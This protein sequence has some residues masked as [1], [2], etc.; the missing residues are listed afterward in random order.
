MDDNID[1]ATEPQLRDY[2]QAGVITGARI[3]RS[4]EGYVLVI[5]VSW[6][7]GELVVYNQRGKPRAWV[8]LDRLI[9][10]LGEVAPS[11]ETLELRLSAEVPKP[12][13]K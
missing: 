3:V 10:H 1:K 6:K 5:R 9:S 11:I 8:S 7:A 12:R 4:D 2:D 13:R